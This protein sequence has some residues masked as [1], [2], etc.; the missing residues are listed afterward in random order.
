MKITLLNIGIA[1]ERLEISRARTVGR[2]AGPRARKRTHAAGS[3]RRPAEAG[4]RGLGEGEELALSA[5]A[6]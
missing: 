6:W 1:G 5:L 3:D 4:H 2:G